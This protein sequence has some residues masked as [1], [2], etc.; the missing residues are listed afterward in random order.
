MRVKRK[1]G[2]LFLVLNLLGYANTKEIGL[3][4]L[5]INKKIKTNSTKVY[6]IQDEIYVELQQLL[7]ILEITNNRWINEAFTIDEN[8]IYGLEKKIN[9]EKKYLQKGNEKISIENQMFEQDEKI[10]VKLSFL[11]TLLGITEIDKNDDNLVIKMRTSFLL[12]IE[13][14]NIRKYKRDEFLRGDNASKKKINL[15]RKLIAPGNL[16]LVYNY[17]NTFQPSKYEYKYLDG[18]YL[19]PLLYGDLEL[20]YGIYPEVENYQTRLKYVDVYKGHDIV[21]GDMPVNMPETLRGTIGGI[22]GISFTKNYSIMTEY[23]EDMIT[24]TGQAPMGKFVELYKNGQLLSYE[25][26]HNGQYKFENVSSIF[27][28]DSFQIIIYNLDGSIKKEN[29]NRYSDTRLEKKGEFGY[30]IQVGESSD[31]GNYGQYIAEINYGLTDGLTLNTGFYDLKYRSYYLGS[32]IQNTKNIKLGFINVGSFG[33]NPYTVNF[34]ILGDQ[35]SNVDNY[36]DVSQTYRDYNFTA[37]LGKYSNN[38]SKRLNKKNELYLTASKSRVYFDNLTIGLKYYE[39]DYSYGTKD[40]EIGAS[41]RTRF[42]SL[43]PEYT[44]TKNTEKDATYHDFSVRSYYFPNYTLYAG[45]YHRE[46][47][48]YNDTKYRVEISSRR[49]R[50]NGI[51]YR[52]YYEKSLKYGDVYGVSFDIDYDTWFSGGTS[53]TKMNNR[54]SL[55]TGFTIDKVINLSDVNNK[56]TNVENG[57]IQGKVYLDNNYNGK[58]DPEIDRLLPRTQVSA[59]GI[60]SFSNEDGKYVISNLYPERYEVVVESQNPLYRA[61]YNKYN[62][63]V[64]Q[65]SPMYL[66]IPMYPRK[67]AS[68]NIYFENMALSHRNMKTLYINVVDQKTGQKLEVCVPENDGY[69]TIE[70]LTLGKY[71]LILESVDNPGVSLSEKEIEVTPDI[72]EILIDINAIGNNEKELKYEFMMY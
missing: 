60:T 32:E 22:R 13:L 1:V 24:I 61:Q 39:A 51:R 56:V 10:Y 68:G 35:N 31:F 49:Y 16:R 40:K 37:E 72:D 53:Y 71:K 42:R 48:G 55:N 46:I 29:L 62:I 3:Y 44:I 47:R 14:N 58:Y 18:E 59:K 9:L 5:E 64:G 6:I 66:N 28:T 41:F 34:E 15:Q 11:R 20:Y 38:T 7:Q 65:A 17:G 27:G 19:G 52:A 54:S 8:N 57:N 21:F 25:D 2:L 63:Q 26:V 45:V 23:E 36:I 50:D 30:N 69:F 12:P 4:S 33:E 67:F 70:N 43:T